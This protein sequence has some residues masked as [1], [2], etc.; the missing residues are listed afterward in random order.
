[1]G[2]MRAELAAQQP[3]PALG[4]WQNISLET[5]RGQPAN[6]S[7]LRAENSQEFYTLDKAGHG[8]FKNLPGVLEVFFH[9]EGTNIV[10][11]AWRVPASIEKQVNLEKWSKLVAECVTARRPGT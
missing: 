11:I 7:K 3:P 5:A 8:D 10:V 6:W 9:I 2:K 4:N 1:M